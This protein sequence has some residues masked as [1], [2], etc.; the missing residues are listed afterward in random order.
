MPT[1]ASRAQLPVRA[2]GALSLVIGMA[3][4][5][6]AAVA[7][8]HFKGKTINLYVGNGAGS[9]FDAYGRLLARHMHR[10]IP[11]T[12]NFV[13]QN[14]PGAGGALVN[15]FIARIGPKD[16]TAIAITMP[17]SLLLPLTMDA[18]KFRYDPKE[19]GFIGNA[20]SGTRICLVRTKTG[21]KSF[22]DVQKRKVTMG[23]TAP[24]GAMFDYAKLKAVLLNAQFN[25]VSG[26]KGANDVL[27]GIER[28][29]L[30]GLCGL[31][32]STLKSARPTWLGS[33]DFT[34]LVQVGPKGAKT[35]AELDKI[36]V[37]SIWKFVPNDK[38]PVF[39]LVTSQQ[40]FQRPFIAHPETPPAVL[41]ILRAAF[42]A[43]LNDKETLAEADKMRLAIDPT[44][45]ESVAE[46]LKKM[47]AAPKALL[48]QMAAA[49]K[50]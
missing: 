31:D 38:L 22:E 43:T 26:Y 33:P 1:A 41:K 44:S 34:F 37:P 11:G 49:T 17:G 13:V 15:E 42:L 24:G 48:E 4:A 47:Y 6:T 35:N 5:G 39:E 29:E 46:N 10:H 25:I 30:D 20:D 40:Y 32:I 19:L 27:L 36:G 14:M 23:S 2:F 21:I 3:T 12:P 45:G 8:D 7:A 16:G 50:P 28:E 18:T 9:G